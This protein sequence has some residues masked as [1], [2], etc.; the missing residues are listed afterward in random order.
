MHYLLFILAG[1]YAGSALNV[2]RAI[3]DWDTLVHFDSGIML[4]W[5]GMLAVCRAEER[6]GIAL[7][8]WFSLVVI[9][10][11]PMAFAAAWEICEF[12]SDLTIG[13]VAQG[14]LV[15]TMT[16][17]IAGTLGGLVAIALLALLRR[18]RT[19]APHSLLRAVAGR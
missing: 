15:D 14:G 9:Q 12:V 16:D 4:A 2:Y 10:A 3:D 19:L 18:P 1:P 17:I 11:M 6:T 8:M 7:P 5:L 13:T